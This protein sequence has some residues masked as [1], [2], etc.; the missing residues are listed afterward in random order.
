MVALPEAHHVQPPGCHHGWTVSLS[1]GVTMTQ[2]KQSIP[3]H[4]LHVAADMISVLSDS[5]LTL[6]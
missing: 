3:G 6:V 5:R 1:D 4:S 2:V